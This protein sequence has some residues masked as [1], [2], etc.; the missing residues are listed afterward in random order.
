MKKRLANIIEIALIVALISFYPLM[1][2]YTF[3]HAAA[4]PK[5]R[6]IMNEKCNVGDR[7]FDGL[8]AAMLWPLYWSWE[9]QER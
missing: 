2:I 4:D 8:G 7:A 9:L 6:S 1:A 3:G 5:C